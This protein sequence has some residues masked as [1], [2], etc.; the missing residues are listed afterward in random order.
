MSTYS[1]FSYLTTSGNLAVKAAGAPVINTGAGS[2]YNVLVGQLVVFNPKTN[3][4]LNAGSV[5]TTQ[6]IAIAVG[7][8]GKPG[9]LAT[10]LRYLGKENHNLCDSN[11]KAGVAS[12]DCG[13]PQVLGF[14]IDCTKY[15]EGYTIVV[16]LDDFV[17]RS[18]YGFNERA[19]YV[20]N[21]VTD[22][23]PCD[24]CDPVHNAREVACKLRD[25]IN[26]TFK[27]AD[28]THITHFQRADVKNQYQPFKAV[29]MQD[30]WYKFNLAMGAGAVECEDCVI[31]DAITGITFNDVAENE[32]PSTVFTNTVDPR[33]SGSTLPGQLKRVVDLINDALEPSGGFAWLSRGVGPCCAYTLNVMSCYD[34]FQIDTDDAEAPLTV[35]PV[36]PF[37]ALTVDPYCPDCSS[38][39]T[40]TTPTVG[41]LLYTEPLE[42][43]C[44]CQYPPNLPVPNYY[45]RTIQVYPMGDGWVGNSVWVQELQAMTLPV[46]FGYFWQDKE[47]YQ[48]NGGH[49]KNFRYSRTLRG[50]IPQPD[51]NDS[52]SN[53]ITKCDETYCVYDFLITTTKP[54]K[55]NNAGHYINTDVG[56]VLIPSGDS[57]TKA[58][59][60]TILDALQARGICSPGNV[61]CV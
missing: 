13:T 44:D 33:D 57:T 1:H 56:Y 58:S 39:A 55:F 38:T 45:G 43:P 53:V 42:L 9:T 40:T 19:K 47:R 2:P 59:W 3:T 61:D 31:T 32:S 25:A 5:A 37:E 18:R 51:A 20:F 16:E 29:V 60:E 46:G 6:D 52:V 11:L 27:S 30:N 48:N 36:S 17:V 49:G 24:T 7:V 8:G 28:P 23:Y 15:N 35:V 41:L 22:D 12:P 34:D 14:Y 54:G 26:G 10:D 50:T 4:T 21:I